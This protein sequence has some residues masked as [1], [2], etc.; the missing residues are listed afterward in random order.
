MKERSRGVLADRLGHSGRWALDDNKV[1]NAGRHFG[2]S[3]VASRTLG[4][5]RDRSMSVR[6]DRGAVAQRRT[7]QPVRRGPPGLRA[8]SRGRPCSL[9]QTSPPAA[10]AATGQPGTVD[11]SPEECPWLVAGDEVAL[12]IE[13]MGEIR[14]TVAASARGVWPGKKAA[15]LPKQV[16]PENPPRRAIRASVTSSAPER[17]RLVRSSSRPCAGSGS[18]RTALASGPAPGS[19]TPATD[20]PCAAVHQ[21]RHRYELL[22]GCLALMSMAGVNRRSPSREDVG[23]IQ[24][25]PESGG[26]PGLA[27]SHHRRDDR[28]ACRDQPPAPSSPARPPLLQHPGYRDR[29]R[30]PRGHLP[31]LGKPYA[32]GATGPDSDD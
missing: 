9:R 6:H 30:T 5:R 1:V 8:A 24:P 32:F 2:C 19:P 21:R 12:G 31:R 25:R 26:G 17:S 15:R 28:D 10:A 3:S 20:Q 27:A 16:L 22:T 23:G 13:L 29:R 14:A 18:P 4:L 7:P 11:Y